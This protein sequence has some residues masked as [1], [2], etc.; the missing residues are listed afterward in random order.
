MSQ[1]STSNWKIHGFTEKVSNSV[2]NKFLDSEFVK[3]LKKLDLFCLSETHIG[4]EF[5][6]MLQEYHVY[7]SCRKVIANNRFFGGLCIFTSKLIKDGVKIVKNSHQDIIWLKLRKEFFK[8]DRHL[9]LCFS[10]ISPSNSIYFKNNDFDSDF[11]F[12]HI[13]QD[14]ADF[15]IKGDILLMGDFNAYIPNNAFDYIE[16]DELDQGGHKPGKHGKPGKLREF[17]KL[18]KSQRKLREI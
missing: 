14:C 13:R 3:V 18:S 7:K 12:D 6:V 11:F 10:Y 9:F 1:N 16:N 8:L 4:P 17:E 5:N 15:M 2:T